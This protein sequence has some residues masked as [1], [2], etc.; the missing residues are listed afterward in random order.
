VL[1]DEPVLGNWLVKAAPEE[2]LEGA[3]ITA[4]TRKPKYG[5]ALRRVDLGVS[6]RS[7]AEEAGI[8]PGNAGVRLHRARETLRRQLARSCGTSLDHGCLDWRCGGRRRVEQLQATL[9][10]ATDDQVR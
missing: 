4:A 7:F 10:G 3:C 9:S 8:T 6:I 5:A 1:Q 2:E